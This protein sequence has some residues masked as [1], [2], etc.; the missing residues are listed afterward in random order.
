VLV[1]AFSVSQVR[2]CETPV[3]KLDASI[4]SLLATHSSLL[5]YSG[6]YYQQQV[7]SRL[8]RWPSNACNADRLLIKCSVL[9]ATLFFRNSAST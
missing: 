4:S 7:R 5:A 3:P 1:P 8:S 9:H 6:N 2:A